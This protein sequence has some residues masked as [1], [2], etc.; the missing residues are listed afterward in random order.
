MLVFL[1]VILVFVCIFLV[2]FVLIQSDKG[3]GLAG[4]LG[5]MGGGSNLFGGRGAGNILTKITTGL[6]ISYMVLCSL[7]FFK[8]KGIQGKGKVSSELQKRAMARSSAMPSQALD[9]DQVDPNQGGA[10]DPF[11]LQESEN[12][13]APARSLPSKTQE[14]PSSQTAPAAEQPLDMFGDSENRGK[15]Q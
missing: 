4:S 12:N 14:G 2:V 10:D 7:I 13:A 11:G 8:S 1:I 3:G 15:K 9:Y 5:G 6:A